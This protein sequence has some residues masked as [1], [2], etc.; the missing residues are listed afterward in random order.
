MKITFALCAFLLAGAVTINAAD[1][2]KADPDAK[3]TKMDANNDGKIS[4]EEFTKGAKNQAKAEASFTA[5]DADKDGSL[6]KEE[7]KAAPAKKAK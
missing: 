5:K 6:S 2:P 3:F 4:K 1:K 7:F